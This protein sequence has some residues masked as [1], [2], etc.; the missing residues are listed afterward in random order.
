MARVREDLKA[1]DNIEQAIKPPVGGV[2]FVFGNKPCLFDGTFD[3]QRR[4]DELH[5]LTRS[6][7]R[8]FAL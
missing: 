5:R 6:R 1:I 2:G 8:A 4:P 3:S 7:I